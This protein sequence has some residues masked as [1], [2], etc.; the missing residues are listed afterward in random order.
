MATRIGSNCDHAFKKVKQLLTSADIDISVHY[1]P[2]LPVKL[3]TDVSDYSM[4]CVLAHVMPNEKE[5]PIAYA[6]RV[7]SNA[8]RKYSKVEKEKLAIIFGLFFN[9]YLYARKF[10]LVVDHKLLTTIFCP[11]KSIPQF[12]ANSLRRWAV[13]LSSYQ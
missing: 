2:D 3:V 11:K 8:E 9:Q 12:S 7:L 1:N 13:I 10:I 6:S 4:S 5:K